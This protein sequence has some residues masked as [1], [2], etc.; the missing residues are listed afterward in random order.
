M[1]QTTSENFKHTC[2]VDMW[3]WGFVFGPKIGKN[4]VIFGEIVK[5][6]M[7]MM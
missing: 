2:F 4:K 5:I 3:D 7:F 1:L 6:E